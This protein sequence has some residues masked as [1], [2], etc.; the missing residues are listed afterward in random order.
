MTE[1]LSV[2]V[3]DDGMNCLPCSSHSA[4]EYWEDA[5]Y[6]SSAGSSLGGI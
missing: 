5:G 2:S 4:F 1:R 3:E 6:W